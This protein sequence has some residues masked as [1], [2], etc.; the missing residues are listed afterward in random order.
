MRFSGKLSKEDLSDVRR[1][2]RPKS[3]WPKLILANL[4]GVLLLG[5]IA[6]ATVA[7]LM[8]K[9][10]PN[11]TAL[12]VIWLVIFTIFG[13]SFYAQKNQPRGSFCSSTLVCRTG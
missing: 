2:V 3:Y 11:W 12:A 9:T 10:R 13:W 4:Y 5:A 1:L 8:G 6:W 7:A